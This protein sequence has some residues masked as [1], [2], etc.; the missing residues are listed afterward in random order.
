M[1]Y[2]LYKLNALNGFAVICVCPK[3]Y[4]NNSDCKT[5]RRRIR[6]LCGNDFLGVDQIFCLSHDCIK[7]GVRKTSLEPFAKHIVVVKNKNIHKMIL[8]A[9]CDRVKSRPCQKTCALRT[10]NEAANA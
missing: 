1:I 10:E 4:I 9:L 5:F 8:K 3:A 7:R 6:L 2:K